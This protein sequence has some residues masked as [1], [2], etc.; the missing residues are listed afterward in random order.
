L[1]VHPVLDSCTVDTL[2]L[3]SSHLFLTSTQ[4]KFVRGCVG[5]FGSRDAPSCKYSLGGKTRS[6]DDRPGVA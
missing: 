6:S 4:G 3:I 1:A 5:M 2:N